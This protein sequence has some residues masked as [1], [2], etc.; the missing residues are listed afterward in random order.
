MGRAQG[1]SVAK[2]QGLAN[3]T[4]SLAFDETELLVIA[5]AEA[6]T[7]TPVN[8]PE[9]LFASLRARFSEAQM[10]ELTTSIAWENFRARFT[11]AFLIQSD[12]VDDGA[13]CLV[14]DRPA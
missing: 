1:L 2:L 10:V 8:V 9:E 7:R 11:R 14:P 3:P 13:F 4:A 12:Q 6:M 5:Y